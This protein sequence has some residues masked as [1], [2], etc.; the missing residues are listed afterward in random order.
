MKIEHYEKTEYRDEHHD[1]ALD[2]TAGVNDQPIVNPYFV[3]KK[4]HIPTTDEYVEGILSRNITIL[5]QAITLIESNNPSN[6]EQAQQ[7]I[8]K[9]LPYAGKSVRIGIT[10]VPGAGKSSFIEAIGNMVQKQHHRIAVLAIDPSS[11]RSGGSIL[12]DK[13]RM[14]TI[15]NNPDIFIRPSP[16]AGSLGGVAR[17]TRETIVLCEA[18]G[19]DTIFIE[20]VGVGQS[21][22]AVHSMVDM[23]ML[24]QISGAGDELQG[25]KR[26]IMEMADIMVITKADGENIMKANLAKVQFQ[27][28]LHLFP[29]SESD[30]SA[31]V[32][33]CSSLDGTGL[34]EVWK[35]VEDYIEH[36]ERNGYFIAHRNEQNKYWMYESINETLKSNF[37]LNPIIETK[38]KEVEERVLSAKLSSFIAA[39]ELLDIY[40][41]R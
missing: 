16:S 15:C 4:R 23:F 31:Q 21:E 19:Y 7:I 29:P 28:A 2:V 8:E 13:T 41:K 1:S 39:K 17:K 3:R 35:G 24:L 26:G 38:L 9:C 27:N 36:I 20:T 5:A 37:Y 30:W 12:G 33:T 14:E 34:E 25:I 10:G 11:E 6:Y 22:T 40:F 32:F 18:A